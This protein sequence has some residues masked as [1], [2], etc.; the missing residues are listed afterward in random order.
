MDIHFLPVNLGRASV[1]RSLK[2]SLNRVYD[3][4]DIEP[5]MWACVGYIDRQPVWIAQFAYDGHT[6]E[7][8]GTALLRRYRGWGLGTQFWVQMVQEI[9]PDLVKVVTVTEAGRRLISKAAEILQPLRFDWRHRKA[10]GRMQVQ[11]V[12]HGG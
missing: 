6:L 2:E 4:K 9:A 8:C 5:G 12:G 11:E 3:S 10:N 1:P 7:A